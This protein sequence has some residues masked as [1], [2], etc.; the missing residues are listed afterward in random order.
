L[1]KKLKRDDGTE[2]VRRV[3]IPVV[4]IAYWITLAFH[5]DGTPCIFLDTA[6]GVLKETT[7][8]SSW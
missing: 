2:V 5:D 6:E 7:G 3:I 1:G 8:C 4:I